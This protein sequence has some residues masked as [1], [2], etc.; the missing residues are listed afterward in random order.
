LREAKGVAEV[1]SWVRADR[2]E[3][4]VPLHDAVTDW[5]NTDWPF[6][7]VSYASR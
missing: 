5:L 7:E 1:S 4:D 3:L 6:A 2:A